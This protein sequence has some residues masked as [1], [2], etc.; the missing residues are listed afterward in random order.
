MSFTIGKPLFNVSDKSHKIDIYDATP[1]H[2]QTNEP[3]ELVF[4]REEEKAQLDT[5]IQEFIKKA[6]PYFSKPLESQIFYTRLAHAIYITDCEECAPSMTYNASW[7]PIHVIFSPMVYT[8][9][10]R[11]ISL[12]SCEEKY[13]GTRMIPVNEEDKLRAKR[14]RIKVRRARLRCALARLHV[15]K[16][17]ENYYTKYGNFDGLSDS[18]LSSESEVDSESSEKI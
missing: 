14:M 5:F 10:W 7:I 12:A 9:G 17:A 11:L 8:I 3:H 18:E 2:I 1:I 6:S 16:L 13:P 15:E 4:K